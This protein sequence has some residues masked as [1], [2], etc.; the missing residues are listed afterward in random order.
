MGARFGNCKNFRS[1]VHLSAFLTKISRST[2]TAVGPCFD[3][4][5]HLGNDISLAVYQYYAS[6]QNKTWLSQQGWPVLKAVADFWAGNV[7]PNTTT[8][9][10]N[11]LNETDPDE[12]SN[13]VN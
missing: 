8:R 2:G 1:N 6:T 9:A 11:T 5:K 3:Y 7:V 10:F 12:Y 13:F 4:E